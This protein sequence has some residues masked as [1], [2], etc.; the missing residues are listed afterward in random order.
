[1]CPQSGFL[2]LRWCECSYNYGRA[3][4]VRPTR[5]LTLA[6]AINSAHYWPLR[7]E[8][9]RAG[10][11]VNCGELTG[12]KI[13]TIAGQ[14]LYSMIDGADRSSGVRVAGCGPCMMCWQKAT[15]LLLAHRRRMAANKEPFLSVYMQPY[16]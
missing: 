14:L 4:M 5:G 6:K 16:F 11:A 1:M 7:E 8:E 3:R 10:A 15:A 13:D 12:R 2:S 9:T